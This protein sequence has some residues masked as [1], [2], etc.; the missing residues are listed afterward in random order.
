MQKAIQ[1]GSWEEQHL[2]GFHLYGIPTDDE[3]HITC[4]LL[5]SVVVINFGFSKDTF[6][7]LFKHIRKPPLFNT[8]LSGW[9]DFGIYME[10]ASQEN[11]LS[12]M[13]QK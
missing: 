4:G 6:I 7:S 13:K 2:S 9:V 10:A 8:R 5:H 1:G 12:K 11:L 3:Y